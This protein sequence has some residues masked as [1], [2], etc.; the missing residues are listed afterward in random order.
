MHPITE[1]L[2]LIV[3]SN[4]NT[5]T[6]IVKSKLK[7]HLQNYILD[8]IYSSEYRNLIFYGG[9]CLRKVYKLDRMSEDLDFEVITQSH[10]ELV[11][12]S[13]SFDLNL[14]S[15]KLKNYFVSN[16]K[17]TEVEIKTQKSTNIS[18]ITSKFNVLSEIGLSQFESENLHVKIE[19]NEVEN[20]FLTEITPLSFSRF[21]MLI[22][23]YTLPVLM[24]SKMN[25]CINR[26][27]R[28]GNS[29]VFI[30]G[31]DYY[32]L[33]WY[34]QKNVMPDVNKLI[35]LNINEAFIEIDSIVNDIQ[36]NDLYLDLAPFFEKEEYIKSW[37]QN[38]HALYKKYRAFYEK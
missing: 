16:L 7:E 23:H 32:D 17:F 15:E 28:K 35:K 36:P 1:E 10:S 24:A 34:M 9:T 4:R 6:Q 8:F 38:F 11:S 14:F 12:K 26:T 37:C 33:I 31:R 18:R 30:K 5:N 25:A 3:S 22:K 29:D 20:E 2:K 13:S 21:N 19:I 27:F